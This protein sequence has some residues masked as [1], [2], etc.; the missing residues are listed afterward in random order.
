MLTDALTSKT[1]KDYYAGVLA[2]VMAVLVAE[3]ILGMF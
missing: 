2:I 1:A 3:L